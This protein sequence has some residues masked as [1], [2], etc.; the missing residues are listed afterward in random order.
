M[1][2]ALSQ[3][4]RAPSGD[5]VAAVIEQLAALCP[6]RRP[7]EAQHLQEISSRLY[8]E[9]GSMRHQVKNPREFELRYFTLLSDV[10]RSL[11]LNKLPFTRIRQHYFDESYI[12][13]L[14]WFVCRAVGFGEKWNK[15]EFSRAR[16]REI[17][18]GPVVS[19]ALEIKGPK[20]KFARLDLS[21]PISNHLYGTL[22]GFT[23]GSFLVKRRHEL[24]SKTNAGG[25]VKA[26]IDVIERVAD[27]RKFIA[28]GT[29][30]TK[31]GPVTFAVIE[32]ETANAKVLRQVRKGKHDIEV[33][34]AAVPMWEFERTLRDPLSSWRLSHVGEPRKLIEAIQHFAKKAA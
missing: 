29:V 31:K 3:S 5:T 20:K 22:L 30:M 26:H 13:L 21:I 32:V 7:L 27:Q 25:A 4:S 10:D 24:S 33:L 34:G 12:P 9:L 18:D 14:S 15:L 1:V 16:I 6:P 28:P 19:H 8:T 17:S 2:L 11:H 23:D